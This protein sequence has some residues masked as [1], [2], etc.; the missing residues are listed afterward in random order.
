MPLPAPSRDAASLARDY[1]TAKEAA[2]LTR[3]S[4]RHW[5]KRASFLAQSAITGSPQAR[6]RQLAILQSPP[7]GGKPVWWVHRSVD[8]RLAHSPDHPTR[9]DGHRHT[10]LAAGVPLE[11]VELAFRRVRWLQRWQEL[12]RGPRVAGVNDQEIRCRVC[13]EAKAADPTLKI[14]PRTLQLWRN[15]YHALADD[16]KIAGVRGLVPRW[17]NAGGSNAGARIPS[18]ASRSDAAVQYFYDLYHDRRQLPINL[19]HEMTLAEAQ[20]QEWAWPASVAATQRWLSERDDLAC[21]CLM[22]EGRDVYARKHESHLQMD[23]SRYQPGEYYVADHTQCDFWVRDRR[24]EWFRPWLTVIQDRVS[25]CIVGWRMGKTPHQRAILD[26]LL[27]AC[28]DWSLPLHLKVDN[29]RDFTCERITG[30]TKQARLR[31]LRTLGPAEYRAQRRRSEE[32]RVGKECRSRW[33]PYH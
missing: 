13:A 17:G 27:M 6:D 21:T 23:F 12:A 9:D 20:R 30:M 11:Y 22:R 5:R 10:L 25:R 1:V 24:G 8:A 29:G 32:R 26:A 4:E 7:D 28:S 33:S 2:R 14:G 19:C 15:A 31:L 18:R 16:G 3:Q